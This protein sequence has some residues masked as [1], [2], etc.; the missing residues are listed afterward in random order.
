MCLILQNKTKMAIFLKR[1]F[2]IL[3]RLIS[4]E[5]LACAQSYFHTTVYQKEIPT[6]FYK[7]VNQLYQ[8]SIQNNFEIFVVRSEFS[9]HWLSRKLSYKK[10][11]LKQLLLITIIL[12]NY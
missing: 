6:S 11:F 9:S 3:I 1:N 4:Q 2:G 10:V 8:M 5:F 7:Y 12:E